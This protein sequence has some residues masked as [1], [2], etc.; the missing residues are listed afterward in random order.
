MSDLAWI[1]GNLS[2]FM[3]DG[4]SKVHQVLTFATSLSTVIIIGRQQVVVSNVN[5]A[6][7]TTDVNYFARMNECANLN[8]Q[9]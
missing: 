9:S 5:Y 8:L 3:S 6:T 1:W 2:K 7:T 4:A